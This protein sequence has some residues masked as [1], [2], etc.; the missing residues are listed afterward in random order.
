MNACTG[1][2]AIQLLAAALTFLV[3]IVWLEVF[4][5][6]ISD[7]L[8]DGDIAIALRKRTWLNAF[9]A[10]GA[11]GAAV[12]LLFWVSACTNGGL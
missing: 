1:L 8:H 2:S 11:L 10:I 3:T 9:V 7:G 6:R 4:W 5:V 12:A